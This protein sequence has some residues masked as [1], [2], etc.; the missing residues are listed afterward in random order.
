MTEAQT[1]PT[2]RAVTKAELIAVLVAANN[3]AIWAEASHLA[4][5]EENAD[6]IL[7]KYTVV[8]KQADS[9]EAR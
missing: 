4:T 2:P 7:A 5:E 8:E 6:A 1:P 3:Q 9:K